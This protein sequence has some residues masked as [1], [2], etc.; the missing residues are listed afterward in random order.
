[1]LWP[2]GIVTNQTSCPT[3]LE[4]WPREVCSDYPFAHIRLVTLQADGDS[5]LLF[6]CVELLPR[7]VEPLPA[8][9]VP[10]LRLPDGVSAMTSLTVLTSE[11]ALRWYE[12]ALS[13]TL[14]I[15]GKDGSVTVR[16][17]RLAPEPCLG[18]FVVARTSIVPVSWHSGPRMHRMVPMDSLPEAVSA[19]LTP[20]SGG[21]GLRNWLIENCFI[22]L[23]ANPDC[24]GG[25]VL[26]AANPVV[27]NIS[28]Y[29]LRPLPDGREVLG[30]RLVPRNGCSLDTISVRLSE[31]R[32]DGLRSIR[33]VPLDA[34]GEAEVV[35]PQEAWHTALEVSCA[36]RGL[37]SV[38]PHAPFVRSLGF[39]MRPVRG[40]M[41]VEVPA[42]SK[43][44]RSGRHEVPV[45]D[46]RL[47]VS[48]L[49]GRTAV[50]GAAAR[51]CLLLEART[52]PVGLPVEEVIFS[53]D[54]QYAKS[55]VRDL[56]SRA[57]FVDPYFSFGDI[58]DFALSAWSG[59]CQV[60]VLTSARATW[61]K[62]L[63]HL[64]AG[65]LHGDLMLADLEEINRV[66][67]RN[68]MSPVD[69]GVMGD[70]GFHDR[71]LV[72]DDTVWF[73]GSSF[74]SLGDGAMSMASKVRDVSVL[75]PMLLEAAA[76]AKSFS[77]FWARTK[78]KDGA[79]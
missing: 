74:R 15:P 50:S 7:E 29:L 40:T 51:L 9:I 22:D 71:F 58:R 44:Q 77:E 68:G 35:L 38:S 21:S 34:L 27:R 25:L 43:R 76:A 8:Y 69:V 73:F 48:R 33:E 57:L 66:R 59:S 20:K 64:A 19:A 55:F 49:V 24:A 70:P 42:T 79:E 23:V 67:T 1:M 6:A 11:A 4:H 41:S 62:P 63:G 53:D 39:E 16:A 61:T 45:T 5:H 47:T 30:V 36:R 52:A 54:R 26:L 2:N 46:A 37:L 75:L 65:S 56:V 60:S 32:P 10:R 12:N 14:S 28:R 18:E 17:V 31:L 72:L 3:G 78:P 13:G